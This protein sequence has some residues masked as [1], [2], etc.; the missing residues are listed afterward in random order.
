MNE[1]LMRSKPVELFITGLL[2]LHTR[3]VTIYIDFPVPKGHSWQ[4]DRCFLYLPA[5]Y[6]DFTIG[7]V[8]ITYATIHSYFTVGVSTRKP[9]YSEQWPSRRRRGDKQHTL[10]VMCGGI[11][12]YNRVLLKVGYSCAHH[13]SR[14]CSMMQ[15]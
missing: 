9:N 10:C 14:D 11:C 3:T 13:W 15:Q 4:T 5:N 8:L 1:I 6:T 7:A 2:E 12:M